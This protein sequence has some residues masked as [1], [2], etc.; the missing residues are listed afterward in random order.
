MHHLAIV[1]WA[2]AMGLSLSAC[3]H[4]AP[5]AAPSTGP[6]TAAPTA[7][8]GPCDASRVQWL[9]GTRVDD[10]AR[11]RARSEAGARIVRVLA[12]NQPAT[13]D[14]NPERLDV[15]TDDAGIATRVTCG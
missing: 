7:P 8:P 3:S 6:G 1:T 15:T 9:V 5:N 13:M 14:F 12:P 4:T 2:V 11:E 10:A